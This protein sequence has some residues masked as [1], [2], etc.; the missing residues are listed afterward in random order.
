[1]KNRSDAKLPS[2][3]FP[4][5]MGLPSRMI[6]FLLALLAVSTMASSVGAQE[7]DVEEEARVVGRLRAINPEAVPLFEQATR[8]LDGGDFGTAADGYRQVLNV[9]PDFSPA[10]RRLSY[11]TEDVDERIRLAREAL[12]QEDHYYNRIALMQGLFES[13]E[14]GVAAELQRL[15]H[16][17]Y[18]EAGDDPD[19]MTTVGFAALFTNEPALL[20]QAVQ[21]LEQ[22][23]PGQINT[24]Y[25]A[26]MSAGYR[27]NWAE[28]E[29]NM[30]AAGDLG[31]DEE[32]VQ[33]FL[34]ETGISGRKRMKRWA[35]YA[36]AGAL[37]WAL[38][39]VVLFGVGQVLSHATLRTLRDQ[40]GASAELDP[41]TRRI[42]SIYGFV[43]LV[44]SIYYYISIPIIIVGVVGLGGGLIY[45]SFAMGYVPIKLVLLILIG[46]L[47]TLFAM[48]RSLF[49]RPG[50]EDPGPR[51]SE[52]EA[53]ELFEALREVAKRVDTRPVDTV[54]LATDATIAVFERGSLLGRSGGGSERCLI[55]GLGAFN[56][57][58]VSQLKSIL[59]H[60]YGHF[61]NK[62]TGGGG[63]ALHVRRSVSLS[64]QAMAQG[65]TAAWYNPAWLF[66]N[67]FY[68]I[69]LRVSHGA[70]RL[71]EVLA[72]RYAAL[73][74][75]TQSFV[76]GLRH[77]I[78][79]SIEFDLVANLEIRDAVTSARPI[80]NLYSLGVPH[81]WW[82][83]S[84]H[85]SSHKTPVEAVD[86]ALESAL[87]EPTSPYDSHPAPHERFA[88]VE[89]LDVPEPEDRDDSPAWGLLGGGEKIQEAMTATIQE[90]LNAANAYE[91]ST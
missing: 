13:D 36:L 14:P 76:G 12:A 8:A 35:G 85:D 74:Y 54:F 71:Q 33:G 65:G 15:A 88:W 4:G 37:A 60:E 45:A 78:R 64:A 16:K 72:D 5:S 22:S 1:M 77:V 9:A 38:G 44:T 42:R 41:G 27:G 17:V 49:T 61:S 73:S 26:A 80:K 89:A 67:S 21:R 87:A 24:H 3:T 75:G 82:S 59:A 66:L 2:T 63:L 40:K 7:R 34:D 79:R 30:V 25:L 56:G 43:I 51:L 23:R 47:V 69:F 28:A 18:L 32:I 29:R 20:E 46:V 50:Q 57:M 52:E 83:G 19:A 68:R 48:I 84:D 11:V 58:T 90:N 39:L 62:D 6:T 55:L 31:L 81:H 86:A 53:P 91:T 10:L 70:S